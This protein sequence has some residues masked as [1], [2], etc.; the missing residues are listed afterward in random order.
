MRSHNGLCS[1]DAHLDVVTWINSPTSEPL[2][3]ACC[4]VKKQLKCYSMPVC[5]ANARVLRQPMGKVGLYIVLYAHINVHSLQ[6]LDKE[7]MGK[8]RK[9]NPGVSSSAHISPSNGRTSVSW[10]RGSRH[11]I[12]PSN[13][14]ASPLSPREVACPA[15]DGQ[16]CAGPGPSVIK[17]PSCAVTSGIEAGVIHDPVSAPSEGHTQ[18]LTGQLRVREHLGAVTAGLPHRTNFPPVLIVTNEAPRQRSGRPGVAVE[19]R[20][21]QPGHF[22]K[23]PHKERHTIPADS[24]GSPSEGALPVASVH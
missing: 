16:V 12:C 23:P 8:R 14:A 15:Q 20:E 19:G 10:R 17:R 1:T 6:E 24:R 5:R 9:I 7:L 18:T 4:D 21:R 22:D 13:V 3:P 11:N 2:A